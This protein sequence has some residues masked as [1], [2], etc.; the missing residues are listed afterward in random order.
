MK[1]WTVIT[2]MLC[3]F[4]SKIGNAAE[5]RDACSTCSTNLNFEL[6]AQMLTF[7]KYG[8]NTVLLGNIN[9]GII[10]YYSVYRQQG[11]NGEY[12]FTEITEISVPP[13]EQSQ[14]DLAV[15]AANNVRARRSL[16]LTDDVAGSAWEL[17]G[18]PFMEQTV[19]NTYRNDGSTVEYL[20]AY[21]GHMLGLFG[22]VFDL[23]FNV[24]IEFPDG[25]W[26]TFLF[27]GFINGEIQLRFVESRDLDGNIIKLGAD[28]FSTQ[29]YKFTEQ[30]SSG[31]GNFM[32]AAVRTGVTLVSTSTGQNFRGSIDCQ[33]SL[34]CSVTIIDK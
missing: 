34:L 31:I 27:T 5:I 13:Y 30:G 24:K 9:N 2:L 3:A 21:S 12:G 16:E 1:K 20:L 33:I 25:S 11:T 23:N 18:Q 32:S 6:K 10:K 14:F 7:N 4:I 19:I 22:K 26:A 28:T 17:V 8:T 29:N 15:A